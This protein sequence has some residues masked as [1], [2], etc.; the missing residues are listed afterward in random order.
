[1]GAEARTVTPHNTEILAEWCGG[2]AVRQYHPLTGDRV[3]GLSVPT[4]SGIERAY[5]GDTILMDADGICRIVK[6]PPTNNPS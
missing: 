3:P 1:M 2:V 5:V 4:M 6:H